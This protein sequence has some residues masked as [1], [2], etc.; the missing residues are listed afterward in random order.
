MNLYFLFSEVCEYG[1][2]Y[3]WGYC[4]IIF[5]IDEVISGSMVAL[6]WRERWHEE[7]G[8]RETTEEDI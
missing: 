6:N 3:I 8:M 7:R 1:I 4:N 5:F 2:S